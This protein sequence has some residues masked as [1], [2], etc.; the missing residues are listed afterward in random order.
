MPVQVTEIKLIDKHTKKLL[1]VYDVPAI[2]VKNVI[3]L[4]YHTS[5]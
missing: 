4:E 1:F 5:L 2:F 3:H